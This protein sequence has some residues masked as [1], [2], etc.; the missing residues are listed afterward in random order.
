[1]VSLLIPYFLTWIGI[2]IGSVHDFTAMAVFLTVIGV[3]WTAIACTAKGFSGR[4]ILIAEAV[5]AVIWIVCKFFP[6]LGAKILGGAVGLGIA[7]FIVALVYVY[8]FAPSEDKASQGGQKERNERLPNRIYDDSN[9]P[10]ECTWRSSTSQETDY[11][12]QKTGET[13]RIYHYRI[14]KDSAQTDKG[15]FRWR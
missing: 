6:M 2:I 11:V 12:N 15:T 7:I 5:H 4:G 14:S 10:W 9:T 8:F 1:M 3:V 13:M